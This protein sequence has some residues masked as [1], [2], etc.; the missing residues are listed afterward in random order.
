MGGSANGGSAGAD[1]GAAGAGAAAGT[2]AGG[3]AGAGGALPCGGCEGS[4][5]CKYNVCIPNLGTCQSYDD[6]PGDSY[7]DDDGQ[8]IPYGTPPAK[9]NDDLCKKPAVP[10]KVT[11]VVQCEWAGP[12]AGD[13]TAGFTEIYSTPA[14]AD[15]N[16]DLDPKKLQPSIVVSTFDFLK[17]PD[18]KDHRLGLLRVFDGRTCEEQM[19]IGGPDD[20]DADGNRVSYASNWAIADLDGDVGTPN[21]H[22]ELIGFHRV[23][24][25]YNADP[26]YPVAF[27]IDSTDPKKPKLVK[28]WEGRDCKT[29]KLVQTGNNSNTAGIAVRDL[30]DDGKPEVLLGKLVF[31]ANGCMLNPK[32]PGFNNHIVT[33]ADV[34]L[35]GT[36]ELIDVDGV[37]SWDK[38]AK[39]WVRPSWVTVTANFSG[40][41]VAVADVGAFSKL[42]G[43]TD[44]LK[45]P[46]II[47]TGDGNLRVQDLAGNTVF[48]PYPV[49]DGGS[50]G[51]P[52]AA[53]F[54]GDGQVEFA[55][56]GGKAY[57][58]YDPDCAPGADAT[59]RPGGACVQKDGSAE[60][61]LWS[62]PSQD[63][64]SN[65]T[66]SSVFDFDGDGSAEVVYRDECYVR[67]YKG[68]TGEVVYSAPASSGTGVEY[69][70]IVDVDGDFA[71]EIVVTRTTGGPGCPAVDP[72]NPDSGTFER[73]TGFAVL[74]DPQDRWASSRAIWNEHDYHV[75]NITDDARVYQSSLEKHNWTEP[76]LNNFRT[77]VQ[78]GAGGLKL[79]DLTVEIQDTFQ[80]CNAT[81]KTTVSA[82][83]CN[84][85]T[86]PVQ[87]G[88]TVAF[89]KVL[90]A[91]TS[92]LCS[93]ET[94][95][96][97]AVGACTTVTCEGDL[98][99]GGDVLV[100]VDPEGK[101]ADC[102]P[103]NNKGASARVLCGKDL[104]L[105]R[106][107]PR[108]TTPCGS[109]RRR[110]CGS[111]PRGEKPELPG[112]FGH[113]A[114]LGDVGFA[115][116]AHE[117]MHE[118]LVAAGDERTDHGDVEIRPAGPVRDGFSAKRDGPA[119]TC[120]A[121]LFEEP[122]VGEL[123]ASVE[124][125]PDEGAVFP[126]ELEQTDRA[127]EIVGEP[128]FEALARVARLANHPRAE[129]GDEGL[130]HL[131][132]ASVFAFEVAVERAF[133]HARA[134]GDGLDGSGLDA[135]F[136]ETL[137]GAGQQ[138]RFR[139][140]GSAAGHGVIGYR[141]VT[142]GSN[143]HLA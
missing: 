38:T 104:L 61:V 59:K 39:T 132:P 107:L 69:P 120:L 129:V 30:D 111:G 103:G 78:G 106:D 6:C 114:P 57:S 4:F 110:P 73:K 87:D 22:P 21:G 138:H 20:Q 86:N 74:R 50:G 139:I 29:N 98:S 43:F 75:T 10:A 101:I 126:T 112:L 142:G 97:L 134:A 85:G 81:G 93:A 60:G 56:A 123:G 91:T 9:K 131:S 118:C 46:E 45:L 17:D 80:L 53:D 133:R 33:Y 55:T 19:R 8:C 76:G 115:G 143:G 70:I 3:A 63:G 77:N 23:G 14:V 68:K 137:A 141:L 44:D 42:P 71:T 66:G 109:C 13:P 113:A 119:A 84:R 40:S 31:D 108:G 52:T 18:N 122:D 26:A 127:R 72:L 96:L 140:R 27:K 100:T 34:D 83:V 62:Q 11:P 36:L 47:V 135:F 92:A 54:D 15:L 51:P 105:C 67:V 58:V 95:T 7:C 65:I 16:L 2:D 99:A 37:Y 136:D 116:A 5:I 28:L 41:F 79:A 125:H 102:H 12:K 117:L 89:D 25:S 121:E 48:G 128:G 49:V 35:D 32:S 24:K 64:S 130:E 88:A 94:V 82:K 1:A 90:G 124:D